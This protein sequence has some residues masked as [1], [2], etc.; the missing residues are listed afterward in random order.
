MLETA[1]VGA[2]DVVY[3]LGSGDGRIVIAAALLFGA[4]GVGVEIDHELVVL[5]RRNAQDAGVADLVTFQENDLFRV[6]LSG[7]S[8]V[9]LYLLP[10]V[11][12]RLQPKLLAE[13]AP[14]S[15]VVSHAFDM[16]DWEPDLE[17]QMDDRWVFYWIVP[18]RVA[19]DWHW[20]IGESRLAASIT[21]RFQRAAG[22]VLRQSAELEMSAVV[23]EG[24]SPSTSTRS[25]RVDRL[26]SDTRGEWRGTR[27]RVRWRSRGV[28]S[29]EL[30]AGMRNGTR[31]PQP[32]LW[33]PVPR[34]PGKERFQYTSQPGVS[35]ARTH[36]A[37]RS[38]V[39]HRGRLHLES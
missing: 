31:S 20:S 5:A 35:R 25:R 19:G 38:R 12:H 10:I 15:R 8:I 21:H 37:H 30:V 27:F 9:T 11:N 39:V 2:D 32:K 29:R 22:K 3:D 6:D 14:G 23:L 4:R 18:A 28:R 1:A 13:L 16:A 34:R 26:Y 36:R 17:F 33:E 7:A 24:R